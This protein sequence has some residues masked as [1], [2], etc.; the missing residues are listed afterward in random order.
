VSCANS[1]RI[2]GHIH[3]ARMLIIAS[4]MHIV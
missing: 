4:K 2:N 3:L 1:K